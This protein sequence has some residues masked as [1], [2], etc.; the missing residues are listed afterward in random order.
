L[1][2]RIFHE[3]T[4][5]AFFLLLSECGKSGGRQMNRNETERMGDVPFL[6]VVDSTELP[7]KGMMAYGNPIRTSVACGGLT[8]GG[9]SSSSGVKWMT[10]YSES[11][12]EPEQH[13]LVWH[14]ACF[15]F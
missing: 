8:R 5:V 2:G 10:I 6:F 3:L 11:D 14:N 1:P 9:A 4:N 12:E 15:A 13:A 7:S